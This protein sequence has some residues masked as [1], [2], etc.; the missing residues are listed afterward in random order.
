MCGPRKN[1]TDQAKKK[2]KWDSRRQLL[3]FVF[4][5][6]P[7]KLMLSWK[8]QHLALLESVCIHSF[9]HSLSQSIH[10]VL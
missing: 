10:H 2:P 8:D 5:H 6:S 1:G 4:K 7:N 3:H 9:I